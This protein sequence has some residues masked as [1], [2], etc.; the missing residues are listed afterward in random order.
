MLDYA[1]SFEDVLR[2]M[3]YY[4]LITAVMCLC[5][6][7]ANAAEFNV[8]RMTQFDV[9]GTPYGKR[10]RENSPLLSINST[11]FPLISYHSQVVVLLP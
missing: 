5:T 4:I 9:Q 3:P 2:G 6:S 8:N 10:E 11:S 1:N 7:S